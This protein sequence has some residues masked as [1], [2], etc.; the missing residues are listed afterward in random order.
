MALNQAR[1]ELNGGSEW[2]QLAAGPDD[3]IALGG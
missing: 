1:E 3:V 2:S